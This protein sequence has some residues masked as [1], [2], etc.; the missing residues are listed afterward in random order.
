MLAA[1]AYNFSLLRG[2]CIKLL[3]G[4]R[5]SKFVHATIK[6]AHYRPRIAVD[7]ATWVIAWQ[8]SQEKRD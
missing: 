7:E 4:P 5:K 8:K 2:V 3:T 6:L 1:A